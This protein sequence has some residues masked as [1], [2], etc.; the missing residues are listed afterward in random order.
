MS[1]E[2]ST[3]IY[4]PQPIEIDDETES[5]FYEPPTRQWWVVARRAL[6]TA[7]LLAIGAAVAIVAMESKPIAG[8]LPT[9][10]AGT[11]EVTIRRFLGESGERYIIG[12]A[13]IDGRESDDEWT[14]VVAAELL[15]LTDAG[16][17]VDGLHYYEV[18]ISEQ[19][20]IWHVARTPAEVTGPVMAPRQPVMLGTP[21]DSAPVSAIQGYLDWFLTGSEGAYNIPRP[22]PA[23]YVSATITGLGI[24][25]GPGETSIASVQVIGLDRFGHALDLSYELTLVLHRGSW[26]VAT[27]EAP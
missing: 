19:E 6:A 22:V 1:E 16:F 18:R 4:F 12:M 10:V 15:A 26:I 21:D 14:V 20:G 11:A 2:M 25:P 13:V 3:A 27:D 23:P 24:V 17:V 8:H 5:G 7:L 9:A